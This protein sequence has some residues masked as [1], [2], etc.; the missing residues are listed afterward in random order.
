[1]DLL[2]VMFLQT[3]E[4]N[5]KQSCSIKC[6]KQ[7]YKYLQFGFQIPTYINV[8]KQKQKQKHRDIQIKDWKKIYQNANSDSLEVGL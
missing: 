5:G 8:K 2:E 1:M 6:F 7:A 4:G 3:N